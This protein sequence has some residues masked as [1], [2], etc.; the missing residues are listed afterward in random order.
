M[1]TIADNIELEEE[2]FGTFDKGKIPFL[3]NSVKDYFTSIGVVSNKPVVI[4]HQDNGQPMCCAVPNSDIH[5]IKLS[6]GGDYWCQWVY[7]FAHEFC[8][9]LIDGP[10]TGEIMG[11]KWLEESICHVASYVC[12]DN[13]TRIGPQGYK[14]AVIGYLQ[15][16]M[17]NSGEI[18]YESYMPNEQN[19]DRVDTIPQDCFVPLQEYLQKMK[20]RLESEYLT[21]AYK[22]ISRAVFPHFYNNKHLW[23]ILP[24]MGDTRQW[25]SVEELYDHLKAHA[26]DDYRQSLDEMMGCLM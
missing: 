9:H 12:L 8:H 22:H 1:L 11:L 4:L 7:Q 13:L 21:C 24:H 2:G 26:T 20:S 6:T 23:Q 3:I 14:N 19:P 5:L 25:Q 15:E 18:M 16:L 10:M 17:C